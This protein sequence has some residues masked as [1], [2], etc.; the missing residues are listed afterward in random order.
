MTELQ[1][2][3]HGMPW[4]RR[5]VQCEAGD[6]SSALGEAAFKYAPD[7]AILRDA[8]YAG[9]RWAEFSESVPYVATVKY[10]EGTR[11]ERGS[12]ALPMDQQEI[13]Q[14]LRDLAAIQ[15]PANLGTEENRAWRVACR[16]AAAILEHAVPDAPPGYRHEL[17]KIDKSSA[18]EE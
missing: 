3:I 11:I 6:S 8:F 18:A 16:E 7:N 5:C 2:C 10:D 15:H 12:F 9:V 1:D 17:V 4:D 14:R 13:I